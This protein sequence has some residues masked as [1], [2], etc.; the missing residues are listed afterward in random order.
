M[1]EFPVQNDITIADLDM[2]RMSQDMSRAISTGTNTPRV[3]MATASAEFKDEFEN[4]DLV[5]AKGM[6]CWETLSELP[7]EGKVFYLLKAKCQPVARSLGVPLNSYV[8]LIR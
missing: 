2:F 4:A 1:K 5:L 8:A 7:A 3:D 6:G